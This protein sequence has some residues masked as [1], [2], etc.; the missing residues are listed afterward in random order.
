[1]PIPL[2]EPQRAEELF[3]DW[4][5][6]ILWAC[7]QDV[8]GKV[9]AD[10]SENPRSAIAVLGDFCFLAGVPDKEL[11]LHPMQSEK[12]SRNSL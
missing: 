8:M 2:K 3:G 10:D 11:V 12:R 5:E 4:Q 1:M 7:L 9:Y 6:A